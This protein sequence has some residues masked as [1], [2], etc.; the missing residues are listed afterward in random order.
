VEAALSPAPIA[1]SAPHATAP[2]L[3]TA[4]SIGASRSVTTD[5]RPARTA[6]ARSVEV[7]TMAATPV[8]VPK[9]R[10]FARDAGRRWA[11]PPETNDA[12]SLVVTEL[13]T[14]V[15]LH[16]GSP[17]VTVLLEFDGVALTVEIKDAGTW[18]TD[19]PPRRPDDPEATHGRGLDLV[20]HCT[21][22]WL[23][24]LTPSGTRVVA[25]LPVR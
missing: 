19:S 5:A 4:V 16:S 7:C 10:H 17:A 9:L 25:S 24:F 18:R 13:V 21:S 11:L 3:S 12:L 8:A 2:E 20:R 6:P 14:N 22:W 1:D 15:V 23:A